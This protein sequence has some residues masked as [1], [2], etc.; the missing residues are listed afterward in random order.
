[1]KCQ[2]KFQEKEENEYKYAESYEKGGGE[3]IMIRFNGNLMRK[4][5]DETLIFIKQNECRQDDTKDKDKKQQK[6]E[7]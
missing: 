3:I 5:L 1:M 6:T 7:S 4:R 2:R